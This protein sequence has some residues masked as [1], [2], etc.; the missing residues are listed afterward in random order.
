MLVQSSTM[1]V[2]E[3]KNIPLVDLLAR[4]GHQPAEVRQGGNDVWYLSPFRQEKTPSFHIHQG[5]NVWYDFGD[6]SSEGGNLIDFV[7]RQQQCSF[8]RAMA[9]LEK[10]YGR[11]VHVASLWNQPSAVATVAA[12]GDK[13]L[14]DKVQPLQNQ[15]LRQYLQSRGID[16]RIASHWVQEAYYHHRDTRKQYFGIAFAN[17]CGG[18]ELRN[19]YFKTSLGAKG[20]SFLGGKDAT[21]CSIFEGFFDFLAYLCLEGIQV[22]LPQ[23]VL[24]LNSLSF[25]EQGF[26]LLESRDY[27]QVDSYLDNDEA[28][29]S[30]TLELIYRMGEQRVQPQHRRYKGYKD[31]SAWWEKEGKGVGLAK[32]NT[33]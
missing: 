15:A 29:A 27:H 20:I 12:P 7:M 16:P 2:P 9:F 21:R 3:A 8:A 26:S 6:G 28:G 4:L 11:G 14:L 25:Q 18:Y 24:V 32:M 30:A 23:D 31:L 17:G 13:F 1:T 22:D 10:L 33:Y 5:R 19:P